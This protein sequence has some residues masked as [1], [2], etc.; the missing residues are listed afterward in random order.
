MRRTLPKTRASST[1]IHRGRCSH[2]PTMTSS[3]RYVKSIH[4]FLGKKWQR[5]DAIFGTRHWNCKHWRHS[6]KYWEKI[7][8]QSF[9]L[10]LIFLNLF[11]I[12]FLFF[13]KNRPGN[14]LLV[15]L[16]IYSDVCPFQEVINSENFDKFSWK[17]ISFFWK[18][19]ELGLSRAGNLDNWKFWVDL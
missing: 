9:L 13:T 2:S 19:N 4:F 3:F 10:L 7:C 8:F 18:A 14:G 1:M 6:E 11:P 17:Q 5:K 16:Y 15:Q 12:Y